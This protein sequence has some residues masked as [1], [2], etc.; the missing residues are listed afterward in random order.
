[1]GRPGTYEQLLQVILVD[2]VPET[3]RRTRVLSHKE[4]LSAGGAS[5]GPLLALLLILLH[6]SSPSPE[7]GGIDSAGWSLAL[8]RNIIRVGMLSFLLVEP[9]GFLL[10]RTA[11]EGSSRDG[12]PT[13]ACDDDVPAW[14]QARAC[15]LPKR[16]LI[17]I[18]TDIVWAGTQISGS[19]S[20]AYVPLFF[21]KDFAMSPGMFMLVRFFEN[22]MLSSMNA[23][24]PK[25]V[26][27]LGRGW[28]AIAFLMA[29]AVLMLCFA[30]TSVGWIA[31]VLFILRT[32]TA[33]ANVPCTQSIIFECVAARHRGKWTAVTSFKAVSNGAGAWLGGYLAD[34]TG[35]YRT[36]F[37][38][39][40]SLHGIFAV[41]L[42]PVAC[43]LPRG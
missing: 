4:M 35:D 7:G 19:L 9:F 28:A 31:A 26:A 16:W 39:T 32:A 17:P 34:R 15:G 11:V 3:E 22:I 38:L 2:N 37:E 42:I 29:G 43:W 24:T 30:Q 36:A 20:L 1:M 10:D 18:W 27:A 40:G 41:L 25:I 14:T 21:R 33:R 13:P 12:K 6:P 8:L 23:A 5:A